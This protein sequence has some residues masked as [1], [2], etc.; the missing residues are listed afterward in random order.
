MANF[1]TNLTYTSPSITTSPP[2]INTLTCDPSVMPSIL[3]NYTSTFPKGSTYC[4]INFPYHL[5]RLQHCCGGGEVL[6]WNNCTQYCKTNKDA[7]EFY[8]CIPL[9]LGDLGYNSGELHLGALCG[10][11]LTSGESRNR[12]SWFA[13]VLGV[14]AVLAIL[15]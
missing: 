12:I 9:A 13:E 4:Q 6:V 7:D 15:Q 3:F 5:D 11:A 1:S 14:L 8:F 2:V 10:K